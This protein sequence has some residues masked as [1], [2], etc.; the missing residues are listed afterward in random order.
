[1]IKYAVIVSI[2]KIEIKN[3][4]QKKFSYNKSKL[5]ILPIIALICIFAILG[6]DIRNN[7]VHVYNPV[8]SLYNDDSKA[9]FTSAQGKNW[10]DFVLPVVTGEVSIESGN[11]Y[12]TVTNSIMVYS[13]ED[14]IVQECGTSLDG[15]RYIKVK[16]SSDILSIITN[17]D[18]IGVKQGDIVKRGQ[19]IA[20]CIVGEIVTLQLYDGDSQIVSLSI[21]QSKLVWKK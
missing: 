21:S 16:H 13:V 5:F 4:P 7:V 18:I 17:V 20:T 8:S 1:M 9:I 12:M 10:A 19:N 11:V 2:N 14:G 15:I 3:K 6:S